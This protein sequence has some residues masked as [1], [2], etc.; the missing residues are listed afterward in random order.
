THSPS[1]LLGE[2]LARGEVKIGPYALQVLAETVVP[3]TKAKAEAEES[4]LA[5]ALLVTK[6]V[7]RVTAKA[8]MLADIADKYASTGQPDLSLQIVKTAGKATHE[9]LSK[10]IGEDVEAGQ[11][12]QTFFLTDAVEEATTKTSALGWRADEEEQ[13]R[14]A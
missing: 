5:C 3:R 12:D 8:K 6:T 4:P 9:M 11:N 7:E 13:T 10:K 2:K 1:S 14:R